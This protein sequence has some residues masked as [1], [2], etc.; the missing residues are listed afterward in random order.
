MGFIPGDAGME[1]SFTDAMFYE[2]MY[3]TTG[4]ETPSVHDVGVW[5]TGV[6]TV[7]TLP[8]T[9]VYTYVTVPYQADDRF[10]I[11]NGL[12]QVPVADP[13]NLPELSAGEFYAFT[14]TN[15]NKMAVVFYEGDFNKGDLVSITYQRRVANGYVSD[16]TA[17]NGTAR[18]ALYLHYPVMSSGTDCT[19]SAMKGLYHVV[20]PRVMVT[21]PATLDTSRGSASTP[22]ITFSAIDAHRA[23]G[24]WYR[25]VYESLTNGSIPTD[26]SGDVI[27]DKFIPN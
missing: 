23:D 11:I 24:L 25:T 14:S 26:Y 27:Y 9:P 7:N 1:I 4:T 3:S 21:Q 18:G 19:Q 17:E 6:F 5:E 16:I 10:V 13:G 2:D 20:V 8:G 15:T 22:Q 12:T